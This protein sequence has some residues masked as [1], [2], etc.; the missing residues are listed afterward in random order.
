MAYRIDIE[1]TSIRDLNT[2]TW[3]K[4]GAKQPKGIVSKQVIGSSV[5]VG[6]SFKV[7]IEQ[8]LDGIDIVSVID[9]KK[10]TQES[11]SQSIEIGI[12]KDKQMPKVTLTPADKKKSKSGSF[13]K[14]DKSD[15]KFDGR[16]SK[17]ENAST[18]RKR[19]TYL[20]VSWDKTDALMESLSVQEKPIAEF[21]VKGG[22]PAVRAAIKKQNEEAKANNM[23]EVTET[24]LISIAEK[25][26][27]QIRRVQWE[28]RA[29]SALLAG[30]RCPVRELKSL[31][32]SSDPKDESIKEQVNNLKSLVK[33]VVEEQVQQWKTDLKNK[34]ENGEIKEALEL[35][36]SPPDRTAK[37]EATL[38][39]LIV[40]YTNEKLRDEVEPDHWIEIIEMIASS[41]LRT[42]ITVEKIPFDATGA[43]VACAKKFSG[44]IPSLAPLLGLKIPPPPRVSKNTLIISQ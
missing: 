25:L 10:K 13:P 5:K 23:P 43:T 19:P 38:L 44:F 32:A 11:N 12:K 1:I 42:K 18:E 7:E 24:G 15:K 8:S 40:N 28:D 27:P 29:A 37:I 33:T 39:E 6:D 26:L 4:L 41:S 22:L 14:H 2:F 20:K 30:S 17:N 3:R 9:S 31:L 34:A 35:L 16:R 21:L 36:A